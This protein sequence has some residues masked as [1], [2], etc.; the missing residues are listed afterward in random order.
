MEPALPFD[1]GVWLVLESSSHS[2]S[3]STTTSR[4]GVMASFSGCLGRHDHDMSMSID[5][6]AD[7]S[8]R[9]RSCVR[10]AKNVYLSM[11][12]IVLLNRTLV[13][14]AAKSPG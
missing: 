11:Q 6:S 1:T 7:C 14:A 9:A 10:W 2:S 12:L 3:L 4:A 8:M 13:S 5:D